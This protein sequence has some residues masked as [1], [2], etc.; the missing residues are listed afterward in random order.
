M[1]LGAILAPGNK[2]VVTNSALPSP[3]LLRGGGLQA[4]G[5]DGR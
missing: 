2:N 5:G 4:A 3:G 1:Y